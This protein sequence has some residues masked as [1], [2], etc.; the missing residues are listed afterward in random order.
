[1]ESTKRGFNSFYTR[2][3]LLENALRPEM[4][5][6]NLAAEVMPV[7][8]WLLDPRF[9]RN[10]LGT[11]PQI[12]GGHVP[13]NQCHAENPNAGEDIQDYPRSCTWSLTDFSPN[14][15]TG[16]LAQSWTSSRWVPWGH[17]GVSSFQV[18]DFS[19]VVFFNETTK[20]GNQKRELQGEHH[21]LFGA[22]S[23]TE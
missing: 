5:R 9:G 17:L 14:E 3:R 7:A 6:P 15:V 8:R 19:V 12:Q 22:P 1:M 23:K 21:P 11:Y 2:H 18:R 4:L 16:N 20:Y 13:T 10:R